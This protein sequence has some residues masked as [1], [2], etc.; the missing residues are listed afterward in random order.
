[1]QL[2][3]NEDLAALQYTGGTTGTAK[4]AMLTHT[5]L[6]SN[7]LAFAAW[8]RGTAAQETFLTALPLFHI[9][10]MTTSMTV[11]ISL[12]AKMVLMP[13]FEPAK[14]LEAI[15]KHKVTVF[16]GVPTMYPALLANPELGKYDLTS[17]RVC[18]SGASPLPP[19]IQKQFMQVTGGFLAEGYGL[20]EASP[21]THCN[22]VDSTMRT[23]KV[24][25]IGLPLPDTDA[26][27]VDLETGEKTLGVRARQ[28]SWR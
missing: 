15:Q 27:I 26:K 12:A 8:I 23:V 3:P 24:G 1:M 16:C 2:N 14:A 10:G 6:L 18:I 19:Q 22:P 13:R 28:V 9:Y 5:N 20:T 11:P 17:I 21:V 4:G 7:A 25:S